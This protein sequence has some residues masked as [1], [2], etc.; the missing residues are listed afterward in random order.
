M[1]LAFA[2]VL[3][4][5]NIWG[6]VIC[7]GTDIGIDIGASLA[8]ELVRALVLVLALASVLVI[9]LELSTTYYSL[10]ATTFLLVTTT[11]RSRHYKVQCA[12][13]LSGLIPPITRQHNLL[14]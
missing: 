11:Y 2:L 9:V 8:V 6:R 12:L 1:A 14:Y 3:P 10:Q 5:V 7:H 13:L 4:L